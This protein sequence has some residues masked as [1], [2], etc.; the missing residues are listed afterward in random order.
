[1]E[2]LILKKTDRQRRVYIVTYMNPLGPSTPDD[3]VKRVDV[4]YQDDKKDK[5][6]EIRCL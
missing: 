2:K 5:S 6:G 4:I 1:M 3:Q